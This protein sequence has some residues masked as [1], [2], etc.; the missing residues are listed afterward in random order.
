MARPS[1]HPILGDPLDHPR[2]T[3][4]GKAWHFVASKRVKGPD[5][6]TNMG[7]ELHEGMWPQSLR[8]GGQKNDPVGKARPDDLSLICR[9]PVL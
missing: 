2:A 6:R 3:L 9:T 1:V 5:K 7:T 8:S 4:S